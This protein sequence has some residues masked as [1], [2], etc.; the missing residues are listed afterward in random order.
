MA[1]TTTSNVRY[2]NDFVS[3]VSLYSHMLI[4]YRFFVLLSGL[5]HVTSDAEDDG[6]W[7][8]EGVNG[9]MI[10]ADVLGKGHWTDYPSDKPTVALQIPFQ[11][12]KLPDHEILAK[13]VCGIENKSRI[14]QGTESIWRNE[15]LPL[16]GK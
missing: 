8:V 15:Q 14:D 5:A 11:D 9:L 10:A 13:G 12:G 3:D 16:Q 7:I 6:L 1:S 2:I 4:E